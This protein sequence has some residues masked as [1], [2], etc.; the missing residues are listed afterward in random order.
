[1][2]HSSHLSETTPNIC[3][4]SSFH[5]IVNWTHLVFLTVCQIQIHLQQASVT[6]NELLSLYLNGL[7]V[8]LRIDSWWFSTGL[9]S[10]ENSQRSAW[11][12]NLVTPDSSTGMSLTITCSSPTDMFK[13]IW[14]EKQRS[15]FLP[16]ASYFLEKPTQLC[17]LCSES[18]LVYLQVVGVLCIRQCP[19]CHVD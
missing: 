14:E 10:Q 9:W 1:M 2:N 17:F 8:L 7:A 12:L 15:W 5:I 18:W 11:Q 19:C 4:F 13:L 6:Y 3:C 16:D